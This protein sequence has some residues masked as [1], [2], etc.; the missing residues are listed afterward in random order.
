MQKSILSADYKTHPED[1]IVTEVLPIANNLTGNGEHLWLFIQKCNINTTHL[2]ELLAKATHIPIHDIGYSGLK[3]RHAITYQWVS[4]RLPKISNIDTITST[5]NQSLQN[6]EYI[7]ITKFMWHN[8]KLNRGTHKSNQFCIILRNVIGNKLNI[9]NSLKIIKKDGVP[10]LF[11][12]QRFGNNGNNLEQAKTFLQKQISSKNPKRKYSQ[13]E[14]LF[15]SSVRS[16]L[17]NEI[18]KKRIENNT[19]NKAIIG[20]VFNLDGT[21]SLFKSDIDAN[22]N[23]RIATGD[24]HATAPLFGISKKISASEMAL[25]LEQEVFNQSKHQ[26]FINGLLKLGIS[27]ERRA[28][29]VLLKDFYWQWQ[30]E[31]TLQLNFILPTGSFATSVLECLVINLHNQHS[32]TH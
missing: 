8:K 10:N 6:H 11:G 2:L 1:F 24:I 32:S 25:S 15:I 13:K 14:S 5:I 23:H 4:L 7:N 30:N 20:D 27:S 17:F 29:R 21:H 3:D 9:E 19:W 12:E 22:I 26:I 18:L 28:L 16:F 31:D